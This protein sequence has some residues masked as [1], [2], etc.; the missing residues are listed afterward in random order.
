MKGVRPPDGVHHGRFG[1][2][3]RFS[4]RYRD[5]SSLALLYFLQFEPPSLA[6]LLEAA[7]TPGDTFVDVGANIGVYAGWA[8]RLVGP[9]GVVY[10]FEPVPRTV[11]FLRSF[12]GLN[13]LDRVNVV[14]LAVGASPGH[15]EL[16]TVAHHSGISSA[17]GLSVPRSAKSEAI[18]VQVTTLDRFLL[19]E[20]ET[21]VQLLKID[22]E[23]WELE[24]L[25]GARQ[26]LASA[27]GP[28][29]VFE[30]QDLTLSRAGTSLAEIRTWLLDQV[31]YVTYALTPR[32]PAQL[33]DLDS[34]TPST[35]ALA[36]HPSRHRSLLELLST[37]RFR[38]NQTC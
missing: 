33:S 21:R 20:G 11:E 14:P 18:T 16:N 7:L 23:G 38:R 17:V 12:V 26:L 9:T 36:V 2:N 15:V 1:P 6:L 29:V 32:G 13:E 27:D 34:H 35:N 8:A 3:L 19:E 30:S 28:A 5:D 37:A 4:V 31:G 25:R 24:V 22:V 10:A